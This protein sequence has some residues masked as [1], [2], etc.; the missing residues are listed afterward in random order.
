MDGVAD[1]NGDGKSDVLVGTLSG[2]RV[3]VFNGSADFSTVSAPSTVITGQ[4]SVGFGRQFVDVGD[5]DADGKDDYAISAPLLGNGRIYIFKGRAAWNPTYNADSDADY[6]LDLGASYAATFLGSSI[7]RLGDFNGDGVDDF[8]VSSNGFNGGRGRVVVILGRAGFSAATL[9]LQ[10]IDGDPAYPSGAFG[11]AVL[12]MGRFYVGTSGTTL[13]VT[14]PAAGVNTRG[15]VYAFQGI[16]GTSVSI[17]ATSANNFVEGPVDT[18]GYG[19]SIGL[20]GAISGVTGLMLSTGRSTALGNGIVD[21]HYGS[22]MQGPFVTSPVRFTDSLA[23]VFAGELFGRVIGGSAFAG[24]SITTSLIG[25]GKPDV[26]M[27]PTTESSGGPSRIYI[28]DGARLFAVSSPADVVTAADVILPMPSDWKTLPLQRN[29]MI[30]D[31][32]G[33]GYGDFAI[34]ENISTGAGRLA[35]FW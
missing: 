25:D 20:A 12:G 7:S 29:A 9:N 19:N 15:R 3:Y 8:A 5:I 27:A 34:G 16:P 17:N 28:V 26:I 1:L 22:A 11:T 24:T 2:Q 18:G 23:A 13:V 6:I 30:R 31:L 35:V 32:D 4:A 10:T 21:V 14:A 33:D